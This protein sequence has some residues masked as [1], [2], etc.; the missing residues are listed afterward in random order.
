[1][2]ATATLA[3]PPAETPSGMRRTMIVG[4]AILGSFVYFI[5]LLSASLALPHMQGAF[6]AAPDQVAWLLTSF[7]IGTTAVITATGWLS[8]RFGRKLVFLVAIAG[9][10]FSSLLC[11]LATTLT[12]E[13]IYRTLQG[14]LGAPL[15][16]VGMAIVIDSYPREKQGLGTAIWGV[17]ALS[18]GVFGPVVGG[19][20]VEAL[21][22]PWVFYINIPIGIA[23]FI[24]SLLFVPEI[25]RDPERRLDWLGLGV[26]VIGMT[27]LTLMLN[28]GERL[29]WFASREV[30][31]EGAITVLAIYVYVA[32]S[33]TTSRPFLEPALFRDRNYV[34]NLFFAAV[35]G[36]LIIMPTYLLPLLLQNFGGFS[37][38]LVGLL[39]AIRSLGYV[40]CSLALSPFLDRLDPRMLLAIGL[41]A[42]A[43]P[44]WA[45]SEWT[46]DIRIWD[47]IWIS[48]IQ[49]LGSGFVYTPVA[50]MAFS[51]LPIRHRTEAM[52]LFHLTLNLA[53]SIGVAALFYLLVVYSQVN[54]EVLA[55]HVSPYNELFRLPVIKDLWDLSQ[56]TSLAAIESEISRQAGMIAFNNNFLLIAL[57]TLV[58]LPLIPFIRLPPRPGR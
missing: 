41:V 3:M 53:S 13:V 32:H 4:S 7:I 2:T 52:A 54:H 24:G 28:R 11:G 34:I 40:V 47:V 12:E 14:A 9:F 16:P 10:T 48:I 39:L 31:I 29:G 55:A 49:G 57:L 35:F 8:V 36:G 33:L 23:A 21:S 30:V 25:P 6:S 42:V 44:T 46:L 1:M 50:L 37:V 38:P 27:A 45:M 19:F 51:T 43:A 17:G 58:T 26:L 18:G 56:Q 5:T 15:M 22:W 20:L